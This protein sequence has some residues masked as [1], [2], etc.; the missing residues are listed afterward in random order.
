ME[1][2]EVQVT[3]H[4]LVGSMDN[5]ETVFVEVRTANLGILVLKSPAHAW[6]KLLTA[7][8]TAGDAAAKVRAGLKDRGDPFTVISAFR[9][10]RAAAGR[11]T[12][13]EV[14]IHVATREGIPI[15]MVLSTEQ[16]SALSEALA[17]EVQRPAAR[18]RGH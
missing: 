5:G 4:A 10:T 3:G 17:L 7:F 15:S 14:S 13:G 2:T 11:A 18:P 9:V 16:A 8:R 6:G 1:K 12:T